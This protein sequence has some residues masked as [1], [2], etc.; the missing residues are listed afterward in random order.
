MGAALLRLRD[1]DEELAR[2]AALIDLTRDLAVGGPALASQAFEA[3]LVDELQL[4]VAPI[5]VGGGKPALP[6][7]VRLKLELLD[8]RRFDS[9]MVH[10]RYGTASE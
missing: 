10:L 1:G 8:E 4:F 7:D 5:V 2:P 6:A 9:G 3:G